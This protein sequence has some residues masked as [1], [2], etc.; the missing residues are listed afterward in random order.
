MIKINQ[1][2]YGIVVQKL[3]H[4]DIRGVANNR[5]PSYLISLESNIVSVKM[6]SIA[7]GSTFNVVSLKVLFQE[8][9]LFFKIISMILTVQ[10]YKSFTLQ[11]SRMNN[12]V[13]HDLNNVTKFQDFLD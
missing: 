9:L 4:Y 6:V 5:F 12:K 13:N 2:H 11:P 1:Y 10:S 8:T 7:I 3:N